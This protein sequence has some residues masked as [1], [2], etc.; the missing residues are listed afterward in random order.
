VRV[1]HRQLIIPKSP[2]AKA[3]GDFFYAWDL[4]ESLDTNS[5]LK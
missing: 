4:V 5:L 1:S 2:S 3:E